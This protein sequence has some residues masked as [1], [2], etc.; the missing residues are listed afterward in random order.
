[1]FQFSGHRSTHFLLLTVF[2][3]ALFGAA[4]FLVTLLTG[5]AFLAALLTGAA[6]FGAALLTVLL[7]AVFDVG[8]A[9]ALAIKMKK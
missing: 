7:A 5:A 3:V 2:L 1:M 4:A 9:A 8:L 6:F